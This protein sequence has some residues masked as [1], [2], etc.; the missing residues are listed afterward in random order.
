V[1]LFARAGAGLAAADAWTSLG[2]TYRDTGLPAAAIEAWR[3]T[4]SILDDLDH[5]YAAAVRGRL[6]G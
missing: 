2:D 3:S 1:T 5:P 6:G 4:L